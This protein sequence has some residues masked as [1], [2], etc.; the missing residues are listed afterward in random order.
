MNR[1]ILIGS[2]VAVFVF[3]AIGIGMTAAHLISKPTTI[4]VAVPIR[5][6][7]ENAI[8]VR[9]LE[10]KFFYMKH[11]G[12]FGGAGAG[13]MGA[14]QVTCFSVEQFVELVP[15]NEPVYVALQY[16]KTE[17]GYDD[18]TTLTKVYWAFIE[19]RTGIM[20]YEDVYQYK[21][22]ASVDFPLSEIKNYNSE[23]VIFNSRDSRSLEGGI[24]VVIFGGAIYVYGLYRTV[25]WHWLWEKS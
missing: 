1:R 25:N 21:G 11:M 24:M 13:G 4:E 10:N 3:G 22:N 20:V 5:N 23:R 14:P 7:I 17:N 6:E 12:L 15:P 19:N 9:G 2:I 18:K 16:G 8:E